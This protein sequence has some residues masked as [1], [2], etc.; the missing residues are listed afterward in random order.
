M[1]RVWT[2]DRVFLEG[3]ERMIEQAPKR[4]CNR[5]NLRLGDLTDR[6]LAIA[7]RRRLPSVHNEC[8]R[9]LGFHVLF[10]E[11]TP[12]EPG[13]D[14]PAI[15]VRLLCPGTPAGADVSGCAEWARCE[16][17][18]GGIEAPSDEWVAFLAARCPT[19]PT[20]EHRH[21]AERDQTEPY[22]GAPQAKTCA[23]VNAFNNPDAPG[24]LAEAAWDIIAGRPG[25]HPVEIEVHAAEV[26][27]A[28]GWTESVTFESLEVS[29]R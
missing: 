17:D 5:C 19:S 26:L 20:G 4:D 25:L 27:T 6:E 9:C 2:P 14:S 12:V 24:L 29:A 11:P 8:P 18:A 22:V 15:T 23:Y 16:C 13:D 21:L 10:A 1:R 28:A 7:N 3:S